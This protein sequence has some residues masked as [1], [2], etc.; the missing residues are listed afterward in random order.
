[1][2]LKRAKQEQ[3]EL[4]RLDGF[5]PNERVKD[6]AVQCPLLQQPGLKELVPPVAE[7]NVDVL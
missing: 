2:N 6:A 5:Q 3:I 4:T 7:S 1:M